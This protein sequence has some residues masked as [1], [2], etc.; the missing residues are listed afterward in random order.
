ML[1]LLA[2]GEI[3]GRRLIADEA[4][5]QTSLDGHLRGG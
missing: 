3:G 1:H 5:L 4:A 2:N